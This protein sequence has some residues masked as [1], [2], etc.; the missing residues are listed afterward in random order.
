M[1]T[2]TLLTKAASLAVCFGILVSGPVM[3][4]DGSFVRDV[5]LSATGSL[6]G[7]VLTPSGQPV[8]GAT[9]QLRHAGKAVAVAS[10]TEDGRFTVA[11]VRGGSH[12]VTVG[13]LNTPVRLWASGTAPRAATRVITVSADETIVRAQNYDPYCDNTC[14]PSS[15]FGMLDMITLATVGAATGAL[16]VGIDNN[17]KLDDIEAA[18]P[19]SN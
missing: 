18:L 16:I 15:G 17:N 1:R 5:E 13:S 10:T 9:V 19:A 12:A 14:P 3:A 4:A 11:G 2:H 6:H 7:R 8:S